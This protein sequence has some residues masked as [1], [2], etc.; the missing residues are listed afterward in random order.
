MRIYQDETRNRHFFEEI[1][2]EK[3]I[4]VAQA[5][6]EVHLGFSL[7]LLGP[8]CLKNADMEAHLLREAPLSETDSLHVDGCRQCRKV[9]DG[10]RTGYPAV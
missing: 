4:S 7:L 8:S 1:A 10:F 3:G 5:Q 2:T 9:I 6:R